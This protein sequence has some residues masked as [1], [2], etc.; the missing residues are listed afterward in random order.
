MGFIDTHQHLIYRESFGYGWTADIPALASGDFTPADYASLTAGAGITGTVFMETAVDDVDYQAEA[1]FIAGLV[2]QDGLLGQVASCRPEEESGFSDWLAE[3][4]SL[5]VVGF[6]RV[7]H[8]MPDDLSR[9]ETFRNNIRKIGASGLVFDLCVLAR[10]LPL[11]AELARACDDQIFVLDHC[12]VPDIGADAFESW[13]SGI[14]ALAALPHVQ[15]KLSGVSAYCAP[16]TVGLDTLRRWIDYILDRFGPG[17]IVW[18]GDWPVVNLGT[19]LPDWIRLSRALIAGLSA[20]EQ[21]RIGQ[22]NAQRIYRL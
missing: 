10:Q 20:D 16:G 22:E 17:R 6:R 14:D 3:C 15:V 13:A 19:G 9:G 11:A 21:A 18:G 4:Q 7:L 2:G 8:V 12:G 5:H 1:R